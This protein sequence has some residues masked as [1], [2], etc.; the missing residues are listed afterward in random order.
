MTLAKE[1]PPSNA[2][3][4]YFEQVL[5]LRALEHLIDDPEDP[6]VFDEL[7]VDEAQDLL[8]D[9]Y[10]EVMD[11]IVKG[12]L[13]NGRWRFFGD[14]EQQAIY[15]SSALKI[16]DVLSKHARG[17]PRYLLTRN[18]RNTPRIASF[19]ELLAGFDKGYSAILRPDNGIEPQ[20]VYFESAN[21]QD[22]KLIA[23]L[24]GLFDEGY[25]GRDIV[26]L[27]PRAHGSAAQRITAS[28]W[29]ERLRPVDSAPLGSI[30]FS[31][32]HAFKG[33]EAAVIVVTDVT[34]IGSASDQSLFYVAVTR[35]TERLYVFAS[36]ALKPRILDLLMRPKRG[37]Q[38]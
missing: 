23:L 32:V 21:D 19:V 18:C 35:A 17:T 31:T 16:D 5:P 20:T 37:V 8:S 4:E 1:F 27:S 9:A 15:G 22:T 30:R 13:S 7:I 6:E 29:K 28:P 33:L 11:A 12:G 25:A 38:E 2:T 34:S 14:F 10:L 24:E 3:S 36:A 26:I